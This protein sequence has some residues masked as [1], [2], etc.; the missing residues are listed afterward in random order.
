MGFDRMTFVEP[1][2]LSE[3]NLVTAR[4]FALFSKRY[5]EL[6]PD[7][8]AE[9]DTIYSRIA[10]RFFDPVRKWHRSAHKR[11]KGSPGLGIFEFQHSKARLYCAKTLACMVR[12]DHS[13]FA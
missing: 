3:K 8:P 13:A 5:I 12:K 9:R 6:H 7:C 4:Q 1:S 2:G 11:H 10:W